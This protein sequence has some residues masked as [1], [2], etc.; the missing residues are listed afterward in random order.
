M[1]TGAVDGDIDRPRLTGVGHVRLAVVILNYRTPDMLLDALATLEE[2][3]A[4]P[5]SVVVV[6]DN[7]SQDGSA[8]KI[9]A[10]IEAA[11]FGDWA[12]LVE[13]GR[14]GGFSA[15][16]NVGIRSVDADFYLL[17]NSDTLVRPGAIA[18]LLG[19]A[20]EQPDVGIASPRLEWPDGRPQISCFRDFSPAS[21]M[22]NGAATGPVTRLLSRYDV[23]VPVSNV[24]FD[25]EWTSFACALIRREVIERVGL[26]DEGYFMYFEDADYCR[27]AREAGFRVRHFPHARVVHLRGGSGDVKSSTAALKRRPSYF[28]ESRT[29]YLRKHYGLAGAVAANGLWS[30]GAGLQ[31]ARKAVGHMRS[32][33]NICEREWLDNWTGIFT[34]MTR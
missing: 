16:N 33:G 6:V 1:Q 23:P 10:G 27:A 19:S 30:L 4:L 20:L 8:E 14:N 21:E 12:R 2:Q 13:S 25:V 17:L 5:E 9:A 7:D 28:Y 24:A 29:R 32:D 26:L 31:Q 34:P 15:G 11:G 22:I 18:A 3:V